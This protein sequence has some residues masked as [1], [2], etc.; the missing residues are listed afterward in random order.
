MQHVTMKNPEK[1]GEF[2][3]QLA[4]DESGLLVDVEWVV[5][6]FISQNI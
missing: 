4:N 3:T 5:G 6:I 1:G 2:A